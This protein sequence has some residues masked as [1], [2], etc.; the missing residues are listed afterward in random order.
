[1]QLNHYYHFADT[2]IRVAGS[3]DLPLFCAADIC[4]VL[5]IANSRDAV[6]SLDDDEKASV[7]LTDT[8]SSSRRTITMQAVTESGLYHL[9]FK[10]RKEEARTFRRWV[11]GTVLPA[12]RRTGAYTPA[13]PG[14]ADT[15]ARRL[16]NATAIVADLTAR[17]THPID[18]WNHAVRLVRQIHRPLP[19]RERRAALDRA[20]LATLLTAI[21]AQ[22]PSGNITLAAIEDIVRR[23]SL[24]P[25]LLPLTPRGRSTALSQRIANHPDNLTG[26]HGLRLHRIQR[27][28]TSTFRILPAQPLP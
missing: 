4:A 10:S 5:D 19:A 6:D 8:S 16:R 21:R 13:D 11:T 9:I 20:D 14:D 12:I 25:D 7:A 28:R 22:Q 1:M 26:R 3:P 18:A 27:T 15:P 24:F 17:G 23:H 2:P